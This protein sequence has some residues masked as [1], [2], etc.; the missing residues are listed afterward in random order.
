MSR[1]LSH[2]SPFIDAKGRIFVSNKTLFAMTLSKEMGKVLKVIKLG[3]VNRDS[4][5]NGESL[6]N[7]N[8][9]QNGMGD[10]DPDQSYHELMM[11]RRPKIRW[12]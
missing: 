5:I 7:W 4:S 8:K 9:S 11:K 1:R 6:M 10:G 2:S 12:A 3:L